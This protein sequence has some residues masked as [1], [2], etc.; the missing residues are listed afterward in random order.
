[1]HHGRA[2]RRALPLARFGSRSEHLKVGK[3]GSNS[4]DIT[5][6]S[7]T[8]SGTDGRETAERKSDSTGLGKSDIASIQTTLGHRRRSR[9]R[10]RDERRG[11][12]DRNARDRRPTRESESERR[13]REGEASSATALKWATKTSPET[14]DVR[15]TTKAVDDGLAPLPLPT[16]TKI[17]SKG[18]NGD[19]ARSST[20]LT[21]LTTT[22]AP[23]TS[24][25]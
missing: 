14:H 5:A 13:R 11:G 9:R 1:M 20:T 12:R 23:S 8:D 16:S 2:E 10:S 4:K 6:F 25:P 22:V 18:G 21:T 15:D 17:D 3:T 7:W 24:V 19:G